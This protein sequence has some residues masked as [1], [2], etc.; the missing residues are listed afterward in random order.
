MPDTENGKLSVSETYKD[1][2][3]RKTYRK[4]VLLYNIFSL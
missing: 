1:C 4:T 3:F 2:S